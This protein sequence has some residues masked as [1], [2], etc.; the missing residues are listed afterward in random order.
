MPQWVSGAHL[1]P[2]DCSNVRRVRSLSP[3]HPTA[4]L[5]CIQSPFMPAR[6]IRLS[7]ILVDLLEK[8]GLMPTE[9]GLGKSSEAQTLKEIPASSVATGPGEVQRPRAERLQE[10]D[11]LFPSVTW[12]GGLG[13]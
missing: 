10:M 11:S 8:R 9:P 7:P 4:S 3:G 12:E 5:L 13:A 6:I 2:Y 1:E